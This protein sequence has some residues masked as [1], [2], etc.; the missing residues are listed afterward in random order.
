MVSVI[1]C[2][3]LG[4]VFAFSRSSYLDA[5]DDPAGQLFLTMVLVGYGALLIWVGRLARFPLP[6]RFLTF[7]AGRR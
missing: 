3:L 1:M 6:S 4:I 5:Y 2:A 7:A